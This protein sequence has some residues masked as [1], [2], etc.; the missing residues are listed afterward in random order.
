M[1]VIS[2]THS[3]ATL[4]DMAG[5]KKVLSFIFVGMMTFLQ[6]PILEIIIG[7]FFIDFD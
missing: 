6:I 1:L 3:I 7:T 2:R 4:S 5:M